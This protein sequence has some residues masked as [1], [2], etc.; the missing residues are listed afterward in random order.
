[1]VGGGAL[2][3]HLKT[4]HEKHYAVNAQP[5]ARESAARWFRVWHA[6]AQFLN[7]VMIG[8]LVIY[9]WRAANPRDTLRFVSSVKFRG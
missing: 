7:V 9:V 8:G 2:Q 3:P 4:L 5:A 1:L 6:L